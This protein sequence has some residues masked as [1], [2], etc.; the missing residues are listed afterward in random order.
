MDFVL[1]YVWQD[2]RPLY[3]YCLCFNF[4]VVSFVCYVLFKFFS[5]DIPISILGR[6]RFSW[7]TF[8]YTWKDLR[9]TLG[10]DVLS[11][12]KQNVGALFCNLALRYRYS[13][14]VIILIPLAII[15]ILVHTY[16]VAKR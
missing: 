11:N 1:V 12:V 9:K 5:E 6:D 13:K 14:L 8:I 15:W 16:I 2:L 7:E 4:D 3:L 10:N